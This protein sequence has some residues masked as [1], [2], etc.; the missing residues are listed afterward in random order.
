MRSRARP[1]RTQPFSIR[2]GEQADLLV[3]E[4]GR[5]SGRSRSVVVEEL[6]EEAAKTRLFP[7]IAFRDAPRRAWAIGSGLDVW[8]IVDLLR[9]YDGDEDS[10]RASHPLVTERH[11]QLA[12]AYADRFPEE[13][14]AILEEQHRPLDELRE[15]YPF[16]R[17]AE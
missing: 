1:A 15:L 3:R 6:A 13:I 11:L 12:H 17:V 8:E 4:E 14:E 16:I 5:R 7:G 2:L 10:L 9:S